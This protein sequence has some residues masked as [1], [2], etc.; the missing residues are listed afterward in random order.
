M[1]FVPTGALDDDAPTDDDGDGTETG[2]DADTDPTGPDDSTGP[3]DDSGDTE[4]PT[5]T[6]GDAATTG[7]NGYDGEPGEFTLTF[8]GRDYRMYVPSGYDSDVAIPVLL[9][10]HGAGDSGANFYTF[11]LQAGFSDAAEPAEFILIVPDTKS[12]FSDWP[13]WTGNPNADVGAMQDELAEV[14]ALVDDVGTHYRVDDHQL[15]A[16]GFSN[17]GLFAALPGMAAADRLA[18][19]AV[20]GYGWGGNYLPPGAP[21]RL[22][23]VQFGCGTGDSFFTNA[24]GSESF[25]AAQG[26][27]T[28]LVPAQ[29]VGHSLAGI[30]DALPPPDLFAWMKA[31]PLP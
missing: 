5:A 22:I 7:S 19:L 24:E 30:M 6:T 29:G 23:P 21:P 2:A 1:P 4:D 17:G 8:D 16:Y 28:R 12:P 18:T 9:G 20:L 10:F 25:L 15:H 3:A 26:H 31:R 14:F 13:N 27:D 11:S